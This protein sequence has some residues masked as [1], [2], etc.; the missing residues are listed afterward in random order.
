M[1]AELD[2]GVALETVA[3]RFKCGVRTVRKIKNR[4]AIESQAQTA[5][6]NRKS[7]RPRN[8]LVHC[9]PSKDALP[10]L[11]WGLLARC[12]RTLGSERHRYTIAWLDKLRSGPMAIGGIN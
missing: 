12:R 4:R 9:D 6:G 10:E 7:Y 1:L 8:P 5:K 2:K 11:I 3:D